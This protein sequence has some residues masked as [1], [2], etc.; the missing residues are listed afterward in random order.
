MFN[1]IVVGTDGSPTAE[2]AVRQAGEIARLLG[3]RI[4]LVGGYRESYAFAAGAGAEAYPA[5]LAEDARVATTGVVENA[6]EALRASG[7]EVET[8]CMGG[9]AAD[10]IVD[11]AETS[12]ADLIVVGSKGMKGSRR[13]LLGSVPNRVSHH[14]P[15]SVLI[16]RTA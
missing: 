11:V 3:A 6:A 10:A 8:H 5:N 2:A 7:V 14:A 1:V 4:E 16:V 12:E 9:D 13:Y 15:C